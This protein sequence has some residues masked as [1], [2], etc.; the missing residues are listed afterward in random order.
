VG[1]ERSQLSLVTINEELLEIKSRWSGLK[2]KTR[3]TTAGNRRADNPTPLYPQ[4]L[5]LI[6]SDQQRSSVGIVRLRTKGHG[7]CF[8][9][10]C[11][12]AVL[13]SHTVGYLMVSIQT[14]PWM[15]VRKRIMP[16]DRPLQPAKL[17]RICADIGCCVVSATG[18]D[19]R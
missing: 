16:T 14:Q 12:C 9:L 11:A 5:A 4:K 15:S 18:P 3:L 17:V 1:R 10:L 6:F 8:C 19:S 7:D 13:V 2:K